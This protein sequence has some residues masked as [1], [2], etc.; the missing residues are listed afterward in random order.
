MNE[1]RRTDMK[2][3]IGAFLRLYGCAL[4]MT[5]LRTSDQKTDGTYFFKRK[6]CCLTGNRPIEV[7][8]FP[9]TQVR[10]TRLKD[11]FSRVTSYNKI[12]EYCENMC[13][14]EVF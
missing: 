6:A 8:Y 7:L 4:E 10:R 5:Q 2:K 14:V 13:Q 12:S 1:D 9:G 11:E 3:V